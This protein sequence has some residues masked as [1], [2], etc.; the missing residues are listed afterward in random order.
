MAVSS[1]VASAMY[2][3]TCY[4]CNWIFLVW[5]VELEFWNRPQQITKKKCLYILRH[6]PSL[7]KVVMPCDL[8]QSLAKIYDSRLA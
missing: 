5:D 2:S 1:L 4:L 7:D 6:G 3:D 8:E